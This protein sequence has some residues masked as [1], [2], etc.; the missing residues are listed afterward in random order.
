MDI[1]VYNNTKLAN[2]WFEQIRPNLTRGNS[3]TY[4]CTDYVWN[5]EEKY[6]M[7][8][9]EAGRE[10]EK[11]FEMW[12]CLLQALIVQM[13]TCAVDRKL[14]IQSL[15]PV[16]LK[17]HALIPNLW[18]QS[19]LCLLITCLWSW[20]ATA[21]TEACPTQA[22]SLRQAAHRGS[23]SKTGI[24]K[25]KKQLVY[26]PY[27]FTQG[28]KRSWVPWCNILIPENWFRC[29]LNEP[30]PCCR[31]GRASFHGG[32]VLP[33]SHISGKVIRSCW[34]FLAHIISFE[35]PR[36]SVCR[37]FEFRVWLHYYH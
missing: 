17:R 35:A 4:I 22:G 23:S 1:H 11:S 15:V 24:N 18:W 10:D 2:V 3:Q 33:H 29:F 37:C 34:M 9:F 5:K 27:L 16:L 19:C 8:C 12:I 6:R 14:K 31:D 20:K 7:L 25:R 36:K 30:H 28:T 26:R 32:I 13:W 21:C